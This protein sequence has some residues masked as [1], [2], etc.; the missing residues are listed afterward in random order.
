MTNFCLESFYFSPVLSFVCMCVPE[1]ALCFV[2][3]CAQFL[4][5][6]GLCVSVL[7]V[8][9]GVVWALCSS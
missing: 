1:P 6:W 9:C 8:W 5:V 3:L 4:L 7:C 2:E